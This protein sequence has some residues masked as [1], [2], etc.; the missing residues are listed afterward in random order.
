MSRLSIY[1]YIREEAEQKFLREL[2]LHFANIQTI[3]ISWYLTE[4]TV[5]LR[6]WL[7]ELTR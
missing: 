4:P 3:G 7:L 1:S 6:Y 5:Q 2:L